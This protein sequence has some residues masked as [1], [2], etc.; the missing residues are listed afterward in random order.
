MNT[1]TVFRLF[2]AETRAELL[3]AW[4]TPAFA[5]PTLLLPL[6]FY[7]LFGVLLSPP[8]A[9]NAGYLLA[10]YGVF[11]SL[12]PALFGFGAG[13][14]SERATGALALKQLSPLPGGVFL[15]ARLATTLVF[16]LAVLVGL[17]AIAALFGGV[18]LP[19]GA[20]LALV[21]VHL[22]G[23]L[24]FG[25]LGLVIGL[26]LGSSAAMGITNLVFLALAVLGGLW[27]PVFL[28]P[29]WM[30]YLAAGLPSFHLAEFALTAV[31]RARDPNLLAS[32]LVLLAFVAACGVL[33]RR[34]WHAVVAR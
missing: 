30:Q 2:L 11:A 28:F 26:R 17:Y 34:S 23:V 13:L 33:A 20:W 16:T 21:V 29:G 25:L 3:K 31:G 8:G 32:G 9:G 14:A 4:R 10:T 22:V 15:A 18:A 5:V 19:R 6:A 12:G 24:P 27:M 7:G 1:P